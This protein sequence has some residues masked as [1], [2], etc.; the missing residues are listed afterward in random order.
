MLHGDYQR[1]MALQLFNAVIE[2]ALEFGVCLF[3][4]T[5]NCLALQLAQDVLE[6]GDVV[7]VSP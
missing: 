7:P 1:R 5:G 4:A 2:N 6:G 3:V